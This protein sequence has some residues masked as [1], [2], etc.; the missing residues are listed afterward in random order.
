MWMNDLGYCCTTS[1]TIDTSLT[2]NRSLESILLETN[3]AL[4]E[5]LKMMHVI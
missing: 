4:T 5:A 3:L 1:T 2:E